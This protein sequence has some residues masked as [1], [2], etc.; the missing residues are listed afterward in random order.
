[1]SIKQSAFCDVRAAY[2]KA[3]LAVREAASKL[4]S[5]YGDTASWRYRKG[6]QVKLE[7]L[8][9]ARDRVSDRFYRLLE[10]SPRDWRVGVPHAWVCL[11]LSFEDA[12]RPIN[13]PLSIVPPRAYGAT[14]DMQ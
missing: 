1:M 12:T 10:A 11:H 13:E 9:R 14:T 2:L 7:R 3:D 4:A 6:D 8:R 5:K